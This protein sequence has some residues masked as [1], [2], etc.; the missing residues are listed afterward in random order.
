MNSKHLVLFL[1]SICTIWSCNKSTKAFIDT[2]SNW[3]WEE[4]NTT[5][6]YK[7]KQ[8]DITFIN[9]NE[10]W[11]VNGF[12][13]IFHTNDGGKTWEKQ[14]EMKGT[15][16][17]AIAFLDEN[18]GFVGTVGTD[19]FPNVTD[20]IPLYGT[21]DGGKTWKPV[22]YKGDYVKG[23]CA[24]EIVKE[25]YINH[26]EIAY[27]KHLYAVGRVGSPAN[28]II[29]H[30]DGITWVS[31]PMNTDCSM[32][33]DIKMFNK[34]EGIVCAA[35]DSDIEKSNALILKTLDG[36]RTWKKV[37]QSKRP[38]ES[39]WKASFPTNKIGYVT[40]QSYNPDSTIV[41]Q[42]LVKTINGGKTWKEINLV[43]EFGAREFGIG[44]LN[45]NIGFVGTV[46]SGFETRDGGKSWVKINLGRA[47][48]KIR[49]YT[50]SNGEKYGYSIGVN[51]FKLKKE[52]L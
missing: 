22:S 2:K 41:Q 32:L 44:F 10:G 49:I 47:C 25:Q 43:A 48:N 24:I 14:L 36:G 50:K 17:R 38:F 15:F 7:G 11:Y 1:F 18:I 33:L 40:I 52:N 31:T 12:G 5:E 39:T 37:Y 51:L 8:D 35:S 19:Y 27:K 9:E 21:R 23:I 20:T 16:F 6:P 28:I 29:S 3:K 26:G 4:I 42:R 13:K 46:N 34:N 45:E 30:D